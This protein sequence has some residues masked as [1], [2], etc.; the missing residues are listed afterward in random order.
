MLIM[1]RWWLVDVPYLTTNLARCRKLSHVFCRCMQLKVR[2]TLSGCRFFVLCRG[3]E[4][5]KKKGRNYGPGFCCKKVMTRWPA[6]SGNWTP[7]RLDAFQVKRSIKLDYAL[8]RQAAQNMTGLWHKAHS[9]TYWYSDRN[10]KLAQPASLLHFY[11]GGPQ[12]A[13]EVPGS[14]SRPD[15]WSHQPFQV[16][17]FMNPTTG[18]LTHSQFIAYR[19]TGKSG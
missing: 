4:S 19:H 8:L 14:L 9:H 15:V 3:G 7:Q 16:R 13:K 1:W 6:I 10:L 5:K 2:L 12:A 17:Q 18:K 11:D